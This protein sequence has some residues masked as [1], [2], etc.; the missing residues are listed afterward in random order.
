[1][2]VDNV[3][4]APVPQLKIYVARSILMVARDDQATTLAGYLARQIQGLLK[5]YCLNNAIT[6]FSVAEFRHPLDDSLVIVHRKE[7]RGATSPRNFQ[8]EL[9]RR[10]R[11]DPAPGAYVNRQA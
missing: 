10:N 9:A 1:V 5:S 6:E 11:T 3:D 2:R 8:R 4:T 7:F